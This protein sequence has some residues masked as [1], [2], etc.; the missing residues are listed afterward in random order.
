MGVAYLHIGGL[1]AVG[2]DTS[3]TFLLTISHSGRGLFS[4]SDWNRV[5]RDYALAYPENGRGVGIGPIIGRIVNVTEIDPDDPIVV[6]SA[7]GR[8]ELI[9]ES[10]GIEVLK[11]E[12]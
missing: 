1:Y 12:K 9:C 5:A 11:C 10:S 4:T 8:I 2:F 6:K 3:E 7:S